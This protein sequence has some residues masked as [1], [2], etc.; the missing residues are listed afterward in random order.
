MQASNIHVL[1]PIFDNRENVNFDDDG[2]ILNPNSGN[3]I[4]YSKAKSPY[5]E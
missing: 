5:K 4:D 1:K 3:R 2:K